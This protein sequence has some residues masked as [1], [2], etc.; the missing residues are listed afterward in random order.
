MSKARLKSILLVGLIFSSIVLTCYMWF[1]EK[2][3][4]GGYNFFASMPFSFGREQVQSTLTKESLSDPQRIVVTNVGNRSVYAPDTDEGAAVVQTVKEI[5]K[6]TLSSAESMPAIEEEWN[7]ALKSK[8]MHVVYPVAYDGRLFANI[9][10]VQQ[11]NPAIKTAKEFVISTGDIVSSDIGVYSRDALTGEI[12]KIP[13]KW[14][15]EQL[16]TQIEQTAMDSIGNYSYSFELHFDDHVLDPTKVELQQQDGTA[17][18][19]QP[20]YLESDVLIMPLRSTGRMIKEINPLFDNEYN[21]GMIEDVLRQ[22]GFNTIGA[23]KYMESDNSIVYVENYGT[24]KFHSNGLI[25]YKAVNPE[26]GISLNGATSGASYGSILACVDFVNTLW[27]RALPGQRLNLNI[28]S[29]VVDVRSRDFTLTMDYYAEGTAVCMEIPMNNAHEAMHHAVEIQVMDNRMVS[30]RQVMTYFEP[31]EETV[32]M[33]SA[34]DALDSLFADN[35]WQGETISD[36][37]LTYILNGSSLWQPMWAAKAG[38]QVVTVIG[39]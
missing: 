17:A 3:W 36:L 11:N 28:S 4:P 16:E 8:S 10:G 13:V 34:I 7:G 1:S 31:T 19:Q 6:A 20:A 32:R 24:L 21:R 15:K 39:Q 23:R 14:D 18:A 30:Y 33:G 38:N 35:Q 37:Y 22:F 2:L 12:V 9:L 26:K 5:L 29:D 27:N 25:E